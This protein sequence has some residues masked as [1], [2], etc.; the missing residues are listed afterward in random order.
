PP[1]TTARDRKP[2]ERV[3]YFNG[4]IVPES[5]ARVPFRDTGW[6]HGDGA[7]DMT[8]T[9]NHRL[10]RLKEHIDRLYDS[11]RYLQI[12]PGL[13]PAQ[14]MAITEEVTS[15]NVKLLEP[16]EDCWVGQRISRGIR[17]VPGDNWDYTDGPT[18]IVESMP[19]PLK[20]RAPLYRDGIDVVV[21][22]TRRTP[23]E[24]LSPRAKTHNY[25]NLV[26]AGLEVHALN[27]K[28][29]PILL[30]M[31]GNLT[32]GQGSN[33]FTVKNGTVHTPKVQFVL[34]GISRQTAMEL[35]HGL[36]I[37]CMEADL[38]LFD[39]MTADEVFLT[40]TSLCICGVRSVNDAPVGDGRPPG[41][42]TKALTD[43]YIDYVGCDFVA[44]Y[45]KR[46]ED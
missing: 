1:M 16:D 4:R 40:S 13:S 11:L 30:D 36:D 43:A 3:V 12:D 15:E 33:L 10:F 24:C 14:M 6:L 39:A 28:A 23:P 27:P 37:P 46:L 7:F 5:Q 34:G 25:L 38:D 20:E 29:W 42:V 26:V 8:R 35:A 22:S 18:V 31:N 44:Q 45:L 2:D 17:R 21:P 41:P 19:L 9:F 32:E